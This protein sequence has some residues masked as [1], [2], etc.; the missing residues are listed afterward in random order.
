MP[1]L[2]NCHER[3]LA[4]CGDGV[5]HNVEGPLVVTPLLELLAV[6]KTSAA[7]GAW[8]MARAFDGARDVF[9]YRRCELDEFAARTFER[10]AMLEFAARRIRAERGDADAVLALDR[11]RIPLTRLAVSFRR[12]PALDVPAIDR[13]ILRFFSEF[14][15]FS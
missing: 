11:L 15:A 4:E 9:S 7:A 10:E 2:Q 8:S 6:V 1:A 12:K 14:N 13:G 3:L 5:V